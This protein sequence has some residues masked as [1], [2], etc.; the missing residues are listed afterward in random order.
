MPARGPSEF[1]S[2]WWVTSGGR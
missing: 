2:G 1:T